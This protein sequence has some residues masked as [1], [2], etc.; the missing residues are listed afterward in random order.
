M[1]VESFL[2]GEC[3]AQHLVGFLEVADGEIYVSGSVVSDGS[4]FEELRVVLRVESLLHGSQVI[5]QPVVVEAESSVVDTK[6]IERAGL[7]ES[8]LHGLGDGE[9]LLVRLYGI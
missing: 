3:L 7:H 4:A 5:V 8:V 1:A 2:H 6:V 9:L